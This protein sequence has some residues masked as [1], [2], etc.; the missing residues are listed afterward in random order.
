[1]K[2]IIPTF[3]RVVVQRTQPPARSVGG[4][5]LPETKSQEKP[6]EGKV[7]AVGPGHRDYEG[8]YAPLGLNVG[9]VVLLPEFGGD[10]INMNGEEYAIYRED[11]I[12]AKIEETDTPLEVKKDVKSIPDV[13]NLPKE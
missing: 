7:L 2:R 3:D 1:M 10:E 13:G 12:I 4:I 11:D 6:R 8:K 5:V 9:D